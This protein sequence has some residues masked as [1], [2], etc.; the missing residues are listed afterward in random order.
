MPTTYMLEIYHS[1]NKKDLWMAWQSNSPFMTISTGD[2][3]NPEIWPGS[4]SPVN[5]LCVTS[6]E[7][8][9]WQ[10]L[11]ETKHKVMVYTEETDTAA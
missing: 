1:R 10:G 9:I 4:E 2:Y 7:H 3:I 5:L 8:L 11:E 6:V